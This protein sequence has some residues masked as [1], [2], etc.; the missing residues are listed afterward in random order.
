MDTLSSSSEWSFPPRPDT[1]HVRWI[2]PKH[3]ST[4]YVERADLTMRMSMPFNSLPNAFSKRVKNHAAMVALY[5]M[6]YI[7]GRV[8]QRSA[9][10]LRWNLASIIWSAD[11][12]VALLA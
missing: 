10:R 1:H 2:D 6:Y 12:F 4:S 8:H 11:E 7:F 3:V 5:F 9:Q